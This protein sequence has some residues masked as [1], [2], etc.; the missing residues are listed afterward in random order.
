[1]VTIILI[2]DF[3]IILS[4]NYNDQTSIKHEKGRRTYGQNA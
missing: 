3:S 1:M 4:Y 2:V